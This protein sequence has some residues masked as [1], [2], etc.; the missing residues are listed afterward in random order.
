MIRKL[1][2]AVF[3]LSVTVGIAVGEEIRGVIS[4]VDGNKVT[5]SSGKFNKETKKFEKGTEQTLPV[6][7]DV[8]VLKIVKF[9]KETKKAETAPLEGGLKN[10]VFSKIGE[11]GVFAT[12]VT[13]S[14]NKKITEIRVMGG[15]GKKKK[16]E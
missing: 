5:F 7:D 3:V 15:T 10:D 12:I 1:V 4:K 11:K 14:D 9:D 2:S 6:A 8:K 16:A 13:D